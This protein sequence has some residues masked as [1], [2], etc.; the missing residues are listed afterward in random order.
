[1]SHTDRETVF[2]PTY[3]DDEEIDLMVYKN[4]DRNTPF[5]AKE[6]MKTIKEEKDDGNMSE[7]SDTAYFNGEETE[8]NNRDDDDDDDLDQRFD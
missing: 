4:H 2:V 1:V 8:F 7:G 5:K 6:K 3:D